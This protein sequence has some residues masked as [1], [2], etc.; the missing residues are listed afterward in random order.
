MST[1]DNSL[2]SKNNQNSN[3]DDRI[4]NIDDVS[5]EVKSNFINKT[6]SIKS[7]GKTMYKK[8]TKGELS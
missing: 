4:I 2:I 5:I 1:N 3:N 6:S 8:S 7:D